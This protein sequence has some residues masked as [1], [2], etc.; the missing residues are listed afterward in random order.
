MKRTS[1][2]P[3]A[4]AAGQITHATRVVS[5]IAAASTQ[6][7]IEQLVTDGQ[8]DQDALQRAL[9]KG[10]RLKTKLIPFLKAAFLELATVVKGCLKLLSGDTVITI[11]ATDGTETLAEAGDVFTGWVDDDF[12]N[13]KT[14]KPGK[15]TGETPVQVYEMAENAD[16]AQI[17]GGFDRELDDLCLSQGQIKS[18]AANHRDWLR[19]DG[20]ATFFLFKVGTEFFVAYVR[21]GSDG[22]LGVDAYRFDYGFVWSA[23]SL[24]RVVVPQ[25][26]LGA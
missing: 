11:G 3:A 10:N 13:W 22:D 21:V 7:A 15:A 4:L 2:T 24:R 23:E 5:D 12:K 16:F 25:Q 20:Y 9:G 17:F 6:T 26:P 1:T 8:I 19:K 14:N 18:F